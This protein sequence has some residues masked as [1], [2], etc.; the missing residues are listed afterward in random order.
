MSN[1]K[2]KS[3]DLA[4][5]ELEQLENREMLAGNVG[6]TLVSGILSIT[7]DSLSN[8]I[9]IVDNGGTGLIVRG[10]SATKINGTTNPFNTNSSVVSSVNIQLK[11]ADDVVTLIANNIPG[12]IQF[13]GETGNDQFNVRSSTISGDLI[14]FGGAGNNVV[15]TSRT[16]ISGNVN[17]TASSGA[18]SAS[19][20]NCEIQGNLSFAC[21]V[22]RLSEPV[23]ADKDQLSIVKSAV[24]LVTFLGKDGND[25]LF[26]AESSTKTISFN[27]GANND[28]SIVTRSE[29]TG[30]VTANMGNGDNGAKMN[31]AD[32]SGDFIYSGDNGSDKVIARRS[33]IGNKYKAVTRSGAD[34]VKAEFSEVRGLTYVDLGN[35]NDSAFSD[36]TFHGGTV[37]VFGGLGNDTL[38]KLAA[39]FENSVTVKSGVDILTDQQKLAGITDDDRVFTIGAAYGIISLP[40][41]VNIVCGDGDDY[42]LAFGNAFYDDV[43]VNGGLGVNGLS[44]GIIGGGDTNIFFKTLLTPSIFFPADPVDFVPII[45]NLRSVDVA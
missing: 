37:S 26:V 41:P 17:V 7:G 6:I 13:N 43:I 33:S 22:E 27:G 2:S 24:G 15:S 39:D 31:K 14:F 12:K 32:I 23:L 28:V 45:E 3:S 44:D 36:H 9:R 30:S 25:R 40:A 20:T 21:G 34:V 29:V 35:G 38:F 42:V 4:Y 5:L 19:F 16:L 1:R 8:S 18:D 10:V 11:G